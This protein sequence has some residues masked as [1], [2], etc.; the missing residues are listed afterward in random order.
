M[1][2][3]IHL[4]DLLTPPPDGRQHKL[5][6]V[7]LTFKDACRAV[8]LWHRHHSSPRGHR[9]SIGVCDEAQHLRGVA[10]VGCPIAR[11]HD[12]HFTVEVTRVAT[13]GTP[14]TCSAL[15]G[16]VWRIA[17]D[18]GFHR[19]VTYT[20]H[21]EPGVSLRAAGWRPIAELRPRTGWD[22][23]SRRR[24][25]R[26]TDNVP[27]TLWE[28]STAA[29]H[30]PP[31]IEALRAQLAAQPPCHERDDATLPKPSGTAPC[32]HTHKKQPRHRAAS[33]P[34]GQHPSVDGHSNALTRPHA[35]TE[36][37]NP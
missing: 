14:N 10:I 9:F 34:T 12:Q 15:Y 37:G 32:N 19:V 5:T 26:G 33:P 1:T 3:Q 30:P 4:D 23:P 2:T 13:D 20:Q 7:P 16:A 8:D 25:D 22:T 21:G 18:M 17:K 11:A 27:R 6:I 31:S 28:R 24:T 29:A 35:A 36:Y